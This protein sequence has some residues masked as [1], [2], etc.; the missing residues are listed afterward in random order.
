MTTTLEQLIEKLQS[1]VKSGVNPKI[2]VIMEY[3]LDN[4][5]YPEEN[6]GIFNP[7]K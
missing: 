2:P 3:V 5:D 4:S 7:Q 1:L 6:Y